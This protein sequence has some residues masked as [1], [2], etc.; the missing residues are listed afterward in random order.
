MNFG[1]RNLLF[2]LFPLLLPYIMKLMSMVQAP[3]LLV[4]PTSHQ[5]LHL[6]YIDAPT[7]KHLSAAHRVLRYIKKAPGQ[8]LFYPKESPAQLNVFSDSDWAACPETRRSITGYCIFLGSSLISWKSKK[9]TTVSRSS[10]EAEYRAL[11]ATVCEVQWITF[12]LD[13]LHIQMVKPAA[14]FC[15]NKSAVAIVENHVFH[16]R[17]KHIEI[18]CHLV[19][20]KVTK[21]T[22]KL[23]TISSM[24]QIA[25]GFTKPLPTTQFWNFASKLGIQDLH[26]PA[27]GGMLEDTTHSS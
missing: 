19:R 13:D 8:G 4:V 7:D 20:D 9:Q 23:L 24:N 14:V 2:L 12:L 1:L 15:D 18:D 17:T 25:D 21:G 6:S 10:S 5:K 22:I 16:E 27:Y 3:S 11:A 26:A